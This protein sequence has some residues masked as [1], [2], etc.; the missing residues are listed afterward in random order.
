MA[1]DQGVVKE[2]FETTVATG[3]ESYPAARQIMK[4]KA[5][6]LLAASTDQ[7]TMVR[8]YMAVKAGRGPAE[9]A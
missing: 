3:P 1:L 2:K 9:R 5:D 4:W 7:D 8:L 6:G